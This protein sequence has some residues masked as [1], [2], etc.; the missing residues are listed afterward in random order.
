MYHDYGGIFIISKRSFQ[1]INTS[2]LK[3][4]GFEYKYHGH[5]SFQISKYIILETCGND[6]HLL[7]YDNGAIISVDISNKVDTLC[8]EMLNMNINK[9]NC[10]NFD[11]PMEY[12]PEFYWS[13]I[14]RSDDINVYCKGK[15]NFPE[16]WSCFKSILSDIGIII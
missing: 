16:N 3:L 9:W 1:H 13:L 7:F 15:D 6:Q 14:I 4:H 8:A 10:Q 11:G 12:F 2:N 5:Y